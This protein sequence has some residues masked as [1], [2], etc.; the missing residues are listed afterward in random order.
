MAETMSNKLARCFACNKE[1]FVYECEGCSKQFCVKDMNEHL[2]TLSTQLGELEKERDQFQKILTQQQN[3][4]K[5]LPLMQEID[6]WENDSIMKVKQTAEECRR[7]LIKHKND[8]F[9]EIEKK[10]FHI[11]EQLKNMRRVDEF[12]EINLEELKTQLT[13]LMQEL[14]KPHYTKIQEDPTSFISKISIV[15]SSTISQ[16]GKFRKTRRYLSVHGHKTK[17]SMKISI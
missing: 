1:K 6:E 2:Q 3:D 7:S 8:H 15:I 10:L 12:K 16:R 14:E 11:K 13:Q 5:T 17:Y 4:P 9:I